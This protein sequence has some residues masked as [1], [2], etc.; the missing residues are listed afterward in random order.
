MIILIKC[1]RVRLE[2][3]G[4]V[5]MYVGQCENF[6]TDCNYLYPPSRIK[7]LQYWAVHVNRIGAV[8]QSSKRESQLGTYV[9]E[10]C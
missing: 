2:G 3:L 10:P 5:T 1:G 9:V 6:H 4:L 7:H 8:G